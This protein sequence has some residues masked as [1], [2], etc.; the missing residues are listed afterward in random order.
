MGNGSAE[1]LLCC[2]NTEVSNYTEGIFDVSWERSD[3]LSLNY[4][5]PVGTYS[6][7][8]GLTNKLSRSFAGDIC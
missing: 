3:G 7:T 5:R 1:V 4:I 6:H 2:E 8:N